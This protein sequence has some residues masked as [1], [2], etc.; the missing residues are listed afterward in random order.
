MAGRRGDITE[1]D[2]PELDG[3]TIGVWVFK[4]FAIDDI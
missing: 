2:L 1:G 4:G 3:T